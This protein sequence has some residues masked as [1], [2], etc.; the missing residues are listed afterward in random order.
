MN[1]IKPDIIRKS[2]YYCIT[3]IVV[4]AL[5][6]LSCTLQMAGGTTTETTNGI[7][8]VIL[9]KGEDPANNITVQIRPQNYL[10]DPG[11][12]LDTNTCKNT[13]TDDS[14]RFAFYF[15]NPSP[16]GYVIHALLK[17]SSEGIIDKSI[18]LPLPP[19][20]QGIDRDTV[21]LYMM[22]PLMMENTGSFSGMYR[23]G[24]L[25]NA[26]KMVI[27]F[28]GTDLSSTLECNEIFEIS[29]LPYGKYVMYTSYL[30]SPQ[31]YIDTINI[32]PNTITW[33][34]AIQFVDPYTYYQFKKIKFNTTPTG[35]DIIADV[36]YR[37]PLLIR[38]S[39]DNPEDSLIFAYTKLPGSI[40]FLDERDSLLFYEIENW[41]TL[42]SPKHA[43]IWVCVPI[44]YGNKSTQYIKLGY[45]ASFN[46]GQ[47]KNKVFDR[48]FGYAS[49]W[50]LNETTDTVIYDATAHKYTGSKIS[51]FDPLGVDGFIGHAQRFDGVNDWIKLGE[52][53]SYI[54]NSQEISL[55]AWIYLKSYKC[56]IIQISGGTGQYSRAFL[57]IDSIG[58]VVAGGNAS[59][60][61][62]TPDK[63]VTTT[64][65]LALNTW[66]QIWSVIH[67]RTNTIDIYLNG[68]KVPTEGTVQFEQS[69]T[70]NTNSKY[71]AL[72]SDFTGISGFSN[73][74]IDECH[75]Y[76]G[77]RYP[78]WIKLYYETQ[79]L[80]S[81]FF[82][83]KSR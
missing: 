51:E 11:K 52:D 20:N 3:G 49:A 12:P 40:R 42:S 63:K 65:V 29:G 50:H 16:S 79:R 5:S 83:G 21:M 44:I 13:T 26:D 36:S 53:R 73:C 6:F 54:N 81:P 15:S 80:N 17:D 41:D 19:S 77:P 18:Q 7:I 22:N 33:A 62:A 1:T 46:D 56:N 58:H 76:R 45:G 72:G 48:D 60:T 69:Q 70:P 39:S 27:R 30:I 24:S 38:L 4:S 10:F 34:K 23:R 78:A 68:V 47:N 14:G 74:I 61:P 64:E 8:G 9:T 57:A 43:E 35:A 25:D 55:S 59:D 82:N 66:Y 2:L 71:A 31:T 28:F 37:F 75:I 67:Y 32:F